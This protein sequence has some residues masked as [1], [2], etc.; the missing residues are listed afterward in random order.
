[1]KV[2][3]TS[4]NW[5]RHLTIPTG[6]LTGNCRSRPPTDGS[7]CVRLP[8]FLLPCAQECHRWE[9]PGCHQW[10][11][12]LLPSWSHHFWGSWRSA[13]W[14][15]VTSP[16]IPWN[17]TGFLFSCSVPLM[18]S[19]PQL[20]SQNISKPSRNHGANQATLKLWVRC[21]WPINDLTNWPLRVQCSAPPSMHLTFVRYQ[22]MDLL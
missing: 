1:M 6:V 16:S 22:A 18:D 4:W 10:Y 8:R 15:F 12:R 7:C 13:R 3:L 9:H 5:D 17:T 21:W 14:I 2:S 19:A 20:L 11:T